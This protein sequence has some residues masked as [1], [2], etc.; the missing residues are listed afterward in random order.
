MAC[1]GDS[2][3]YI[4]YDDNCIINYFRKK[5]SGNFD[6]MKYYK[7]SISSLLQSIIKSR[8]T[9]FSLQWLHKNHSHKSMLEWTIS[10]KNIENIK[11]LKPFYT[12]ENPECFMNFI[13]TGNIKLF[14]ILDD[15]MIKQFEDY[16]RETFI[17]YNFI[18]GIVYLHK[19]YKH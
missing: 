3:F 14:E 4:R 12:I 18:D 5:M 17:L 2:R 19:K 16:F 13:G 1:M 6:I 9:L 11:Y 7:V 15:D 10:S 8:P